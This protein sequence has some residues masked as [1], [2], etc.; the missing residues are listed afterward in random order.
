MKKT[1][2]NPTMKVVILK[3]RQT[4]LTTSAHGLDGFGGYGGESNENDEG[5]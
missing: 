2:I 5:D 1:Y 3:S 4:I